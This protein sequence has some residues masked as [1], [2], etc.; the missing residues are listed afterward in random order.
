MRKSFIVLP[1]PDV[2]TFSMENVYMFHHTK[3]TKA[4]VLS[5]GSH[6]IARVFDSYV[7]CSSTF[8]K[9]DVKILELLMMQSGVK[10]GSSC[11]VQQPQEMHYK[12]YRGLS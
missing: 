6:C 1:V 3:L 10:R 8:F 7:V 4:T 11:Y 5:M 12:R 9:F 2:K